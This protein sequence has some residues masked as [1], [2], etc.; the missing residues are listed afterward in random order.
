VSGSVRVV[1]RET[2]L[3]RCRCRS[4]PA[5][6]RDI[7]LPRPRRQMKLRPGPGSTLVITMLLV[8]GDGGAV[9]LNLRSFGV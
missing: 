2:L 8:A 4:D 7:F 6:G 5:S 9:I 3:A 1:N